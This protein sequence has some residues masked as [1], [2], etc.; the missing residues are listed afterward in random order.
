MPPPRPL[1][2]AHRCSIGSATAPIL[3]R[4]KYIAIGAAILKTDVEYLVVEQYRIAGQA[5]ILI[6][7]DAS[8]QRVDAWAPNPSMPTTTIPPV[9]P[10]GPST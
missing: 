5:K 1:P 6:G 8:V 2:T 9:S 10:T 4:T 3:K 7:A